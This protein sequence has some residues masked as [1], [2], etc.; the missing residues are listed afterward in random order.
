MSRRFSNVQWFAEQSLRVGVQS[1]EGQSAC[2]LVRLTSLT[3]REGSPLLHSVTAMWSLWPCEKVG[4]WVTSS[5]ASRETDYILVTL[6]APVGLQLPP[7]K[8][9]HFLWGRAPSVFWEL[10]FHHPHRSPSLVRTTAVTHHVSGWGRSQECPW[11]HQHK[12]H[13]WRGIWTCLLYRDLYLYSVGQVHPEKLSTP[14]SSQGWRGSGWGSWSW[15]GPKKALNQTQP[16]EHSLWAT[17]QMQAP[18][19]V[20]PDVEYCIYGLRHRTPTKFRCSHQV[21]LL[22]CAQSR[23][24]LEL[25]AFIITPDVLLIPVRLALGT[26]TLLWLMALGSYFP[27]GIKQ[28]L[29]SSSP[30]CTDTGC[31]LEYESASSIFPVL[32]GTKIYSSI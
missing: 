11:L 18:L 30:A 5:L 3:S 15:L 23:A 1:A 26:L 29:F 21:L 6:S 14:I 10:H 8:C 20:W 7:A 32:H 25:P 27:T 19:M 2:G 28:H 4:T 31:I 12:V 13:S 17:T 16:G 22:L 9:Q 24:G